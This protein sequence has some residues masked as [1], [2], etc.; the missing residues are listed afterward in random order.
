MDMV[1][2]AGG[3]SRRM[4]D[5]LSET[6][7]KIR[8]ELG[9]ETGLDTAK[10]NGKAFLKFDRFSMIETVISRLRHLFDNVIISS[11]DGKTYADID[12]LEVADIFADG[13]ALGGLHSGLS[14]SSGEKIFAVACDMPFVNPELVKFLTINAES[15]DVVVPRIAGSEINSND[16]T[17]LMLEPLH[18]IYSK[19]CIPHIEQLLEKKNLRIYDFYN[20]VRANFIL[21][22]EIR[23]IDPDMLSFFNINTPDDL[24]K[25]YMLM[26]G[27][28]T[29]MEN[30]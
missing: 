5:S 30:Q 29:D 28:Q 16:L 2:L 17:T 9:L 8:A 11:A 3:K 7:S 10:A 26:T 14:A 15:F 1:V 23:K 4:G 21:P 20:K 13:G 12:A 6:A 25:A 22:E 18:A 19:R 27:K 24:R